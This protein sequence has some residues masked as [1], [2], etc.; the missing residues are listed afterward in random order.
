MP[1]AAALPWLMGAGA[2]AIPWLMR[3]PK[4]AQAIGGKLGK[5]VFTPGRPEI[6]KPIKLEK[7]P[8]GAR[9]IDAVPPGGFVG[10]HPIISSAGLGYGGTVAGSMMAG[11]PDEPTASPRGNVPLTM[12]GVA[13]A[14]TTRR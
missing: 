4:I 1:F 6:C 3:N 12:P 9:P 14:A 13:P 11:S 2:G 10:R 5:K 7:V 8:S